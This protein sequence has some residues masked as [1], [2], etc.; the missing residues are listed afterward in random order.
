MSPP[1]QEVAYAVA[2]ART[3]PAS[4][5]ANTRDRLAGPRRTVPVVHRGRDAVY[6]ED[7][8]WALGVVGPAASRVPCALVLAAPI[9]LGAVEGVEVGAGGLVLLGTAPTEITPARLVETRVPR[10]AHPGRRVAQRLLPTARTARLELG[11]RV[12]WLT[13]APERLL[14]LGSGL[15]PLGDDVLSG[16]AAMSCA[17]GAPAADLHPRRRTTLLSA[18]L[19]DHARRGEVLPEF[20]DLVVALHGLRRDG[21]L[22]LAQDRASRLLTVGHTS[23]SGLLLGA[24]LR[25]G[26]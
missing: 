23:G 4:A 13:S 15:T 5:A 26:A 11:R 1:R 19:L 22:S 21:D 12:D 14:G 7:E 9:D 6:V 17:L 24:C 16:W 3:L 10:I 8:G 2:P 20:R 18:T 25:L